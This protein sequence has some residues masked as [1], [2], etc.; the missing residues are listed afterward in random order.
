MMTVTL[1]RHLSGLVVRRRIQTPIHARLPKQKR[2]T[3]L[4]IIRSAHRRT[5]SWFGRPLLSQD[6]CAVAWPPVLTELAPT[7]GT[8]VKADLLGT[9]KRKD[10]KLQVTFNGM[11]LY[12]F[13]DDKAAGDLKGQNVNNVWFGL[14]PSGEV[15]KPG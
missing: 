11:P 6:Q 1:M 14:K 4:K 9:T 7:A 2:S 10:G 12:Y 8:G 3:A 13:V 5:R 15:L